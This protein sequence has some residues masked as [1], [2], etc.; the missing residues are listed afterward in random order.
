M[1]PER[2]IYSNSAGDGQVPAGIL[3]D[4]PGKADADGNRHP[5]L[6][7][8]LD[9][10]AVASE[11]WPCG[12]LRDLPEPIRNALLFL[13]ALHDLGKVSETFRRQI[14]GRHVPPVNGR[15]WQLTFRHLRDHVR[16]WLC[17]AE[18]VDPFA[19]CCTVR[20]QAIMASLFLFLTAIPCGDRGRCG[21]APASADACPGYGEG[22]ALDF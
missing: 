9:V 7:H 14:E 10:A 15:H 3:A 11:L 19:P 22:Y 18:E 12:P 8:M 20:L 6:W 16:F 1:A 21:A 13:I 2:P 5:A 4:W 17:F